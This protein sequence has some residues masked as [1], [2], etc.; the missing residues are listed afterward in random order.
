MLKR[1]VDMYKGFRRKGCLKRLR[2]HWKRDWQVYALFLMA[3]WFMAFL[4]IKISYL[5]MTSNCFLC[6]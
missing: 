3:V 4:F 5:V 2:N 6:Q 1:E